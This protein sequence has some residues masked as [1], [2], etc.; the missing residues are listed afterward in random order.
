MA[1]PHKDPYATLGVARDADA[2]TIKRAYRRMAQEHHPDLNQDNSASEEKFKEISAAYSV[3]SDAKRRKDYDEFGGIALDLNFNS[4]RARRAQQS[5]FGGGGFSSQGFEG[6]GGIFD[7]F[8]SNASG[9]YSR[10]RAPQPAKGRD[11]E[12]GIQ[13]DLREASDGCEKTI[14]VRDAAAGAGTES[15][16]VRIPRGTKDDAKIRLAG[17]GNLGDHG[18]PPGDLFCRVKLRPHPVFRV[19]EYNLNLDVPIN[20]NEAILGSEIEIPTLSGRVTLNVPPG[21]DAGSRLR[22]RGKGMA[23]PGDKPAGDLYVTLM[24]QVP[25]D[26]DDAERKKVAEI[27]SL[28][29]AGLRDHLFE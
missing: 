3:L 12:V 22:L 29:P 10:N 28:G 16:R 5:P 9:G 21:T 20:L 19:E 27:A 25:K 26:L 6:G 14:T 23:R 8:F 7:E 15:L 13:L 17:K 2:N 1:A 18:G 4:E 24:I 11:R